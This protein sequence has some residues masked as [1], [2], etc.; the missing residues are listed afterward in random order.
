MYNTDFDTLF[1]HWSNYIY[2][3]SSFDDTHYAEVYLVNWLLNNQRY[4]L[5]VLNKKGFKN[6]N[7]EKCA[8]REIELTSKLDHKNIIR[9]EGTF[10]DTENS[11]ILCEFCEWEDLRAF[12]KN[13]KPLSLDLVRFWAME[14]INAIRYLGSQNLVHRDIKPEN[15]LIDSSFH[16]KLCDFGAAKEFSQNEVE[17]FYTQQSEFEDSE[18]SS[19]TENFWSTRLDLNLDPNELS[20]T[21]QK[22]CSIG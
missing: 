11:Y 2:I 4:A 6:P 19:D 1:D 7:F 13:Y 22:V 8:S 15:I 20:L 5:K 14:I 17:T 3:G 21:K 9:Y 16:I 18:C 12:I 10:E